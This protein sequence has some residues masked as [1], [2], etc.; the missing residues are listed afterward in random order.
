MPKNDLEDKEQE[1]IH[2]QNTGAAEGMVRFFIEHRQGATNS[3]SG[4]HSMDC[5]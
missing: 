1:G 5:R 3:P 4:Y 2:F